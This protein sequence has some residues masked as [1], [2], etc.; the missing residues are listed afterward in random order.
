MIKDPNE[1]PNLANDRQYSATQT[2]LKKHL[3]KNNKKPVAGSA[4][5]IL[6]YKNGVVN[7]EGEDIDPGEAIPD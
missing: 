6:I 3:S 1:F 7:W 5:R 2:A 4:K